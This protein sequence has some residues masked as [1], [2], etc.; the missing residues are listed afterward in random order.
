M[1]VLGEEFTFLHTFGVSFES[2]NHFF[3]DKVVLTLAFSFGL[4]HQV[5]R[6]LQ[7]LLAVFVAME[8]R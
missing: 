1:T 2:I 6:R 5:A 3:G 4:A 7:E 8:D